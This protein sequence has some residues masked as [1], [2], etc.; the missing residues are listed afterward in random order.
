MGPRTQPCVVVG[1]ATTD[2]AMALAD[3]AARAGLRGRLIPIPRVLSAGCGM[4]WREPRDNEAALER[5][6][7]AAGVAADVRAEMALPV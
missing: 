3:E 6:L 7:R 2:D 4:A 1:F 5:A